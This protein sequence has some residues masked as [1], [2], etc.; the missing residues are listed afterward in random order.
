MRLLLLAILALA[1]ACA[2]RPDPAAAPS[3]W[4]P[5]QIADGL[6]SASSA[7][8]AWAAWHAGQTGA[9]AAIP[10]LITLAADPAHAARWAAIDALI[11]LRAAPSATDAAR[12]PPHVVAILLSR[13]PQPERRVLLNLLRTTGQSRPGWTEMAPGTARW[14]PFQGGVARWS[15]LAAIGMLGTPDDA[16]DAEAVAA[17]LSVSRTIV[18][19]D[20][21][22]PSM[23]R[24]G[25][26][27]PRWSST[28]GHPPFRLWYLDHEVRSAGRVVEHWAMPGCTEPPI[29]AVCVDPSPAQGRVTNAELMGPRHVPMPTTAMAAHRLLARWAGLSATGAMADM[30]TISIDEAEPPARWAMMMELQ[31]GYEPDPIEPELARWLEQMRARVLAKVR[32]TVHEETWRHQRILAGLAQRGILADPRLW[33]VEIRLFDGRRDRRFA[34]P[35]QT[36]LQDA[37]EDLR[38]MLAEPGR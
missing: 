34:P 35:G 2:A 7:V 32:R 29:F 8:Q 25:L 5:A 31:A 14:A 17:L 9:A 16:V 33:T 26:A 12:L 4:T 6:R 20:L 38:R 27:Y 36:M 21:G 3:A 28:P 1:S 23:G 22:Y 37:V 18:A 10:A 15:A 30:L 13:Q 24:L 19:V 11:R